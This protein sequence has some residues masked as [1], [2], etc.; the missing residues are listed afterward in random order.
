MRLTPVCPAVHV[1]SWPRAHTYSNARARCTTVCVIIWILPVRRWSVAE[2]GVHGGGKLQHHQPLSR[3]ADMTPINGRIELRPRKGEGSVGVRFLQAV[4]R[5]IWGVCASSL[6][7]V[8]HPGRSRL[9]FSPGSGQRGR[10]PRLLWGRTAWA[11][12]YVGLRRRGSTVVIHS[13]LDHYSGVP[14]LYSTGERSTQR[15]TWLR[16]CHLYL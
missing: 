10:Y 13:T 15:H 12:K 9:L 4:G 3:V 6:Q 14:L 7:G 1:H 16:F 11:P 5:P 8:T 2:M